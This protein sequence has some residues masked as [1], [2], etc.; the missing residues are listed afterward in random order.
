MLYLYTLLC[1]FCLTNQIDSDA[2]SYEVSHVDVY[3][4]TA[5]L[6][7]LR[8]TS[9]ARRHAKSKHQQWLQQLGRAADAGIEIHLWIESH[10]TLAK[11]GLPDI[12]SLGWKCN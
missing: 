12:W 2:G 1:V 7:Y 10:T 9:K 3:G 11:D 8:Q 5:V 6:S 4:V